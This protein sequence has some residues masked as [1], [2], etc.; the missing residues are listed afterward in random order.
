M[1]TVPL[2]CLLSMVLALA[3][4][5][6]PAAETAPEAESDAQAAVRLGVH[7]ETLTVARL[8][9]NQ[10]WSRDRASDG[11]LVQDPQ[12][13]GVRCRKTAT[14]RLVP[15]TVEV[16]WTRDSSSAK[17]CISN[18]LERLTAAEM[19]DLEQVTVDAPWNA[20]LER[21]MLQL[22]PGLVLRLRTSAS[23]RNQV[24][25]LPPDLRSLTVQVSPAAGLAGLT[26]LGRQGKLEE[27][28]LY[29][30]HGVP[31]F[32]LG[33]L[34]PSR[35]SLRILSFAHCWT[36]LKADSLALFANLEYLNVSY[37]SQFG[38]HELA[39]L[40]KLRTIDISG[41]G[42]RSLDFLIDLPE[43][44]VVYAENLPLAALPDKLPPRLRF[45]MVGGIPMRLQ[46]L[47]AW[48]Q[49]H[50]QCTLGLDGLREYL[51][52]ALAADRLVVFRRGESKEPEA[53]VNNRDE[54]QSLLGLL[55]TIP[56]NW[57]SCCLCHGGPRLE[58]YAG[59]DRLATV[60][61]FGESELAYGGDSGH[62]PVPG[63]CRAGLSNWLL[64][65]R[66]ISKE[67]TDRATR[68]WAAELQFRELLAKVVGAQA[69]HEA[70]SCG[71]PEGYELQAMLLPHMPNR[72]QAIRVW[73]SLWGDCTDW[74][75]ES[76]SLR[77]LLPSGVSD[78]PHE[79]QLAA[80]LDPVGIAEVAVGAPVDHPLFR[81]ALRLFVREHWKEDELEAKRPALLRIFLGYALRQGT[82]RLWD[83]ALERVREMGDG[84]Q[85]LMLLPLVLDS[86][87]PAQGTPLESVAAL[88]HRSFSRQERAELL[89][90]L[91]HVG[92][93]EVQPLIEHALATAA[94]DEERKRLLDAQDALAKPLK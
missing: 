3:A 20:A 78:W 61:V 40:K 42:I 60:T 37:Q 24:P 48:Q 16:G 67:D 41:T 22:P 74:D 26:A 87:V 38:G 44:E 70:Y 76:E 47:M 54:V 4:R 63:R 65:H 91:A 94:S 10:C 79:R 59:K 12:R 1:K 72:A 30:V 9:Q 73:L 88:P 50:P 64:A 19:R 43:L 58:F 80:L 25:V 66:L 51:K 77:R 92:V 90:R 27:V 93:S 89:T 11:V 18:P 56:T 83:E 6:A 62:R 71:Q 86:A 23:G 31:Q 81:G 57:S 32:D 52:N 35:A 69:V 39:P 55:E 82:G 28:H 34:L 8:W 53:E 21:Q 15:V 45:L 17:A 33:L 14:G 84:A 68:M 46:E 29:R 36:P 75:A 49:A 2:L 13:L 5:Q 7:E 85:R